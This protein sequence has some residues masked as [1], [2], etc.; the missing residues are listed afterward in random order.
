[1]KKTIFTIFTLLFL[2]TIAFAQVNITVTNN[3]AVERTGETVEVK[4]DDLARLNS[5]IKP[6]L[7]SVSDNGEKLVTQV[8]DANGDGKPE[9]LIFQIDF[10]P[11]ERIKS[12]AVEASASPSAAVRTYGRFAG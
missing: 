8:V 2:A 5:R 12:L 3:A 7:V 1:M 4:W 11:G 6:D 10:K 9:K